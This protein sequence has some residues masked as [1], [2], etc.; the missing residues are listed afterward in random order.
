MGLKTFFFKQNRDEL[1]GW[2]LANAVGQALGP[3]AE[4][5]PTIRDLPTEEAYRWGRAAQTTES[6]LM[7]KVDAAVWI[8]PQVKR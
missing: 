7:N 5:A 6:I 3:L 4:A 1:W 8:W 2:D